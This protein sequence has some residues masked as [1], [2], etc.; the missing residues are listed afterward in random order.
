MGSNE[1]AGSGDEGNSRMLD[2]VNGISQGVRCG[3]QRKSEG[4]KQFAERRETGKRL[5][6]W[7]FG[8]NQEV[9]LKYARSEDMHWACG[10]NVQS[11]IQGERESTLEQSVSECY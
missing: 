5:A 9:N 8:R 3:H 4:W 1:A 2:P 6:G 10:D 11:E 7:R